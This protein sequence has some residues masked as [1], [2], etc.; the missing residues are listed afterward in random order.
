MKLNTK[1]LSLIVA[2]LSM[3]GTV[4]AGDGNEMSA[5][6]ETAESKLLTA[7][8]IIV[9]KNTDAVAEQKAKEAAEIKAFM[10][11]MTTVI[12]NKAKA[13]GIPVIEIP[14]NRGQGQPAP[15][16]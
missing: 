5:V 9:P 12:V 4:G 10:D 14:S 15:I 11:S 8:Q 1:T 6:P 7:E 16:Q 2:G 13:Q 3:T